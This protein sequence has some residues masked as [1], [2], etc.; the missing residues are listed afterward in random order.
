MEDNWIY[1]GEKRVFHDFENME[2]KF[3]DLKRFSWKSL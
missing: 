1:Y 3:E 2:D